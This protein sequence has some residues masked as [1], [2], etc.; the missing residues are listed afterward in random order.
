[1]DQ[2]ELQSPGV[3]TRKINL[4]TIRI[5]LLGVIGT[6]KLVIKTD[7]NETIRYILRQLQGLIDII[8][9]DL[10]VIEITG[11][12]PEQHTDRFIEENQ[13]PNLTQYNL[14]SPHNS[15]EYSP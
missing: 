9:Q 2:T 7:D 3:N 11:E 6:V 12:L 15:S 8:Q 10:H 4:G 14:N 5:Q 1:M 13:E